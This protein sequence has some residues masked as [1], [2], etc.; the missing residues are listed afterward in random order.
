MAT[1]AIM[2]K[3]MPTVMPTIADLTARADL[4]TIWVGVV[5]LVAAAK[6]VGSTVT[7]LKRVALE[8]FKVVVAWT[9]LGTVEVPA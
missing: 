9:V 4:V 2:S 6:G 5:L 3:G 1:M 7:M 8:T